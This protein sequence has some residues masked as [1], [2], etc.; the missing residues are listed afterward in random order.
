MAGC[1]RGLSTPGGTAIGGAEASEVGRAYGRNVAARRRASS[2]GMPA[3][4]RC[5][6]VVVP[7]RAGRRCNGSTTEDRA[8]ITLRVAL[9]RATETLASVDVAGDDDALGQTAELLGTPRRT[10]PMYKGRRSGSHVQN[11]TCPSLRRAAYRAAFQSRQTVGPAP[12]AAISPG[13]SV[14]RPTCLL[15]SASRPRGT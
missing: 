4:I 14:T 8:S 15:S 2:R 1:L 11:S 12:P 7:R 10:T 6:P 9:S 3:R 5:Q 13:R